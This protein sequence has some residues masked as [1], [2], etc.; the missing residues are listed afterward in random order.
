MDG[1]GV[2][3]AFGG[4]LDSFGNIANSFSQAALAKK[5]QDQSKK[6]ADMSSHL[7]AS[8]MQKEFQQ[9]L[10]L[11]TSLANHGIP[12][13][14][15]YNTLLDQHMANSV[16][17]ARE[18]SGSGSDLL[19]SISGMN[20]SGNASKVALDEQDAQAHE[21][22]ESNLANTLWSVGAEKNNL[23]TI[24]R[25]QQAKL[26]AQSGALS[27]AAT[28]NKYGAV[29]N[30]VGGVLGLAS[31]GAMIGAGLPIGG[32]A[33]TSSPMVNPTNGSDESYYQNRVDGSNA[34]LGD[35]SDN[36]NLSGSNQT[37]QTQQSPANADWA[38]MIGGF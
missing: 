30:A 23:E 29:K 2:S 15:A 28:A 37:V 14:D 38:S 24:K 22:N 13:I 5:Q 19:G 8:P 6:L 33:S 26:N 31:N 10:D 9:A 1:M 16:R 35:G 27:N 20:A 34:Q 18:A 36:T 32:G 3:S 12:N 4:I 7:V 17:A 11:K 21:N 25:M